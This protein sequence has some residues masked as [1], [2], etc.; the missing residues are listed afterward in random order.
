MIMCKTLKAGPVAPNNLD[1]MIR[2]SGLK[3]NMVAELKGIQ[4]ATLS[5]HKSGDIGISLGDAEEYAKIL[6]CTAQQIFFSS[7]PIPV[8][9]AVFHWNDCVTK[10]AEKSAPTP[11]WIARRQK[12]RIDHGP[13]AGTAAHGTISQQSD[14]Y[15]RLLLPR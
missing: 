14:I 11:A 9:A 10:Q 4:P 3:N 8:L 6:N 12:S 5:R 7:P 13:P 15:S 2:R 1:K